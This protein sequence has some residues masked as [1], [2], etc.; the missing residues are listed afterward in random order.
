MAQVSPGLQAGNSGTRTGMSRSG[1]KGIPQQIPE[2]WYFLQD[3]RLLLESSRSLF[4]RLF[5]VQPLF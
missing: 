3:I 2:L 1:A 4:T 5:F